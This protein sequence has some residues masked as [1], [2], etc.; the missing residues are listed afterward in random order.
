MESSKSDN[1]NK[2][3][4]QLLKEID[5]CQ[6]DPSLFDKPDRQKCV[7]LLILEGYSYAHMAQVLKCSEKTI[8]RDMKEIRE[9]N[10][11]S[12]NVQFAKEFIGDVFRKAMS[13]H[14][15]LVRLSR[16]KETPVAER[17]QATFMAWRIL[18][19]LTERCQSL[20][21]LPLQPQKVIG[22]IFHHV[23]ESS[24]ASFEDIRKT[25][26]EIETITKETGGETPQFASEITQLKARLE[27]AQLEYEANKLL[28]AQFKKEKDDGPEN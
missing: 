28:E 20:G 5:S 9:R 6:T 24:E 12:P 26:N 3:A 16:M 14:D 27:K 13:Q 23:E 17:I 15:H 21:Y 19:E 1:S 18:K 11:I 2:P 10:A 22:D 8:S 7:E 25:I 4:V